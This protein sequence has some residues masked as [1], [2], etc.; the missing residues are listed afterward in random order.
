VARFFSDED[1][2]ESWKFV[3]TEI[4]ARNNTISIELILAW[5]ELAGLEYNGATDA[6]INTYWSSFQECMVGQ[7][8]EL[9]TIDRVKGVYPW[10]VWRIA[11]TDAIPDAPTVW[12][13]TVRREDEGSY[14][15][16]T[17][18]TPLTPKN[19]DA[20]AAGDVPELTWHLK[21]A[22]QS[23]REVYIGA[24]NVGEIDAVSMVPHLPHF[25]VSNQGSMALAHWS[26]NPGQGLTQWQRRP[27]VNR[28]QSITNF[29][30]ASDSNLIIN[31]VMLFIPENADGI[32]IEKNGDD[33][34]IRINPMQFLR[35]VGS[36]LTDVTM[37]EDESGEKTFED[38]RP[39]WIVDGQHRTRGMALSN[40]GA[41]ISIPV[42]MTHDGGEG[43]VTLD[44]VA[45]VFT[46]INTLAKPLDEFQQHYLSHKF[47]ITSADTKKT[48]GDPLQAYNDDDAANRRTNINL[49]KLA[50]Y[51]TAEEHG[52]FENGVQLVKGVG[53]AMLS[54]MKLAEFLKQIRPWF[55]KGIYKDSAL[56]IEEI[57]EDVAA[58]LKAWM[59]T[60]NSHEHEYM[61]NTIRWKPNRRQV[62][63]IEH[64]QPLVEIVFKN[65]SFI[66]QVCIKRNYPLDYDGYMK[67]LEPISGLDWHHPKL[68]PRF[69]GQYRPASKWMSTW[70]RQSILHGIVRTPDEIHSTVRSDVDHGA[71]LFADPSE[72]VLQKTEGAISDT[73]TLKWEHGNVFTR[74]TEVYVQTGGESP[75]RVD[76]ENYNWAFTQP[77]ANGDEL[78]TSIA[79]CS[80]TIEEDD[81]VDPVALV[82]KIQNIY[83][84]REYSIALGA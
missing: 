49:Y 11:S 22:E 55:T 72:P 82:F 28:I 65:F 50:S 48:Y 7:R 24:V 14:Q 33:A 42:V 63:E 69:A 32:S 76:L 80:V 16:H 71:A 4:T 19:N 31:S 10:G 38:H 77:N 46:E 36:G 20:I 81:Y 45:K 58:Y 47:S 6:Q 70:V 75:Q 1:K 53:S 78:E 64:S 26:L 8:G 66:R 44:E 39:V 73:Y 57:A 41:N 59:N 40:R 60:A 23:G 17:Y 30:N 21:I 61:P 83:E 5:Q 29:M 35:P 67:A 84:T 3:S 51:L 9:G 68:A 34:T 56:S 2:E 27:D 18:N 52:A 54:R 43:A 62:S 37:T 15:I 25:A 12:E 74:P 13:G 79:T